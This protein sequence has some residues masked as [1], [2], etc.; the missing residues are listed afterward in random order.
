MMIVSIHQPAYLPWLGY[1]D[2]IAKSDLFVCLDNV[3]FE[4]NSFTNRNRIKTARGPT[5][6]TVPVRLDGHFETTIADI[7]I[8]E[9]Q[10]WRRKHLRSIEQNYS[11]TPNFDRKFEHLVTLYQD[12][13]NRL[14]DLCLNQLR[15]WLM[16]LGVS[17]P[18]VRASEL[19][20]SGRKSELV[21]E[22]CQNA[23]ATTYLSGPLGRGYLE[24]DEFSKAGIAVKYHKFVHP[25]YPQLYGDF[26]PAMGVVDYWMNCDEPNVRKGSI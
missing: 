1:F 10:N 23:G 22:L 5:W 3:Q 17:T 19:P 6:L 16:E 13:T 25:T 8:D 21:L 14:A 4:R 2:R 9:M 18:V 24:E 7:E 11:R 12:K 26:L 20:A 15:F